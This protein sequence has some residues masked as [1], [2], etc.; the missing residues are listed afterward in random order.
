MCHALRTDGVSQIRDQLAES[1]RQIIK[2]GNAKINIT[3]F[4]RQWGEVYINEVSN[5]ACH[6]MNDV[7]KTELVDFSDL[8][9]KITLDAF[10]E[11]L[12]ERVIKYSL[13]KKL[14]IGNSEALLTAS[15]KN[16]TDTVFFYTSSDSEESLLEQL[17]YDAIQSLVFESVTQIIQRSFFRNVYPFPTE[18]TTM[19]SVPFIVK[20]SRARTPEVTTENSNQDNVNAPVNLQ[21]PTTKMIAT[22]MSMMSNARQARVSDRIKQSKRIPQIQEYIKYAKVIEDQILRGVIAFSSQD[23][24]I[25]RDLLFSP[26]PNQ[27][28]EIPI[29]SSMTKEL[30][31]LV[32]Y[33][34]FIARPGDWLVIDEPEMNLHPE[35]QAQLM[36]LLSMLTK[37]DISV[38]ITTHSPYMVDHLVNLMRAAEVEDKNNIVDKFFLQTSQAFINKEDVSVHLFENGTSKQILDSEGMIN[39]ETFGNI[40]GRISQI[41]FEI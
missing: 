39:W 18:R 20:P 12:E 16:E 10:M 34:R 32:L 28:I 11:T 22:F 4:V 41:F 5:L 31:S 25:E 13:S 33:L 37:N 29:A 21:K 6:W 7:F 9:V 1:V 8:Q 36:E 24:V 30:S 35:A 2:N 15:K 23:S 38:L 17:P 26:S 27:T 14:S 19:V 3:D 40:S